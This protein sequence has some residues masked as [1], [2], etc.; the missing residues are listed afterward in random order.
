L[1]ARAP[2]ARPWGAYDGGGSPERRPQ[3]WNRRRPR[4]VSRED[5]PMNEKHGGPLGDNR[6]KRSLGGAGEPGG[7]RR[8]GSPPS[9]ERRPCGRM[10]RG[11]DPGGDPTSSE[12]LPLH[13]RSTAVPGRLL[14]APRLP[15]AVPGSGNA[16]S[17]E[18]L[19]RPCPAGVSAARG[20]TERAGA[21]GAAGGSTQRRLERSGDRDVESKRKRRRGGQGRPTSRSGVD[22]P[23][24][25]G[26]T[27]AE[28]ARASIAR[29]WRAYDGG[30]SPERRPQAR[31]RRRPRAVSG[32]DMPMNEKHG[33]PLGDNRLKR[34]LDG[35]GEPGGR[36]RAGS[37]PP[38][39]RSPGGRMLRGREPG[40][41]PSSS[42]AL[43]LHSRSTAVPGRLRCASAPS[44][45]P[46][47]REPQTPVQGKASCVLAP[48]GFPPHAESRSER[49]APLRR[50]DCLRGRPSPARVMR[51]RGASW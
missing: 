46:W 20:I 42:E 17:G 41:D 45:R 39:E 9:E 21:E 8:A 19:L 16:R 3:A 38:E 35:A 48:P 44:R 22:T 15:P 43:P 40:G 34:S 12:V 14:L 24:E 32:E 1:P 11:R 18:G 27:N 50:S 49:G 13:S 10:L 5:M 6:L 33:G 28:P 51:S 7:R 4:A 30:G 2:I 23:R 25:P 31:N 47:L 36:M 26:S 37:P 29:S